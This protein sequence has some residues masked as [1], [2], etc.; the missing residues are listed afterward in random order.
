VEPFRRGDHRVTRLRLGGLSAG[1]LVALARTLGVGDLSGRVVAQLLDHTGGN[2]LHCRALL[3]ELGPDG[4]ARAGDDLPAPRELAGV[5]LTRLR[6]LSEPAQGLVTAAAVLGRR[7]PLAA[8]AELAGLADPLA[9]LDE[10]A[11]AGLLAEDRAGSGAAIIFAH[12]FSF[13]ARIIVSE[14]TLMPSGSCRRW[15]DAPKVAIA[16][17]ASACRWRPD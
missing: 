17:S 1:E 4:L 5:V 11:A 14:L 12:P 8:A 15:I 7:C 16:R 10:A 3:E 6:A 13:T 2:A 9:A